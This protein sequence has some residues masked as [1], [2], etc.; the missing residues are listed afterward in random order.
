M[1]YVNNAAITFFLIVVAMN[2]VPVSINAQLPEPGTFESVFKNGRVA[3]SSALSASN[4]SGLHKFYNSTGHYTL[5]V[6]G[7]GSLNASMSIRVNKPNAQATVKKAVLISSP[8]L[9]GFINNGC[10]TI[11]GVPVNWDGSE[12]NASFNS[13]WADVTS[14]VAPQINSFPAGLSTL[15]ITEC[16]TTDI[17]GEALLVVFDDAT[18]TEKTI[19]IMVGALN[20]LGDNF[21]VTLSNPIN[22]TVPGGFF[23]M[24]LGIGFSVQIGHSSQYSKISLMVACLPLL[25]AAKTMESTLMAL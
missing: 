21:S 3:S 14:I 13:Y 18:A 9:Q 12:S 5:S 24:G 7:I 16:N 6:D 22:P 25:P 15:T 10:V 2:I 8:I 11:A 19:V 1:R 4:G 23:D 20:P 17:D